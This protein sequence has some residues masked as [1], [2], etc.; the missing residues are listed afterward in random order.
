M[1]QEV[2]I[3][4]MSFNPFT[5]IDK[6]WM[7]ITAGNETKCNTMYFSSCYNVLFMI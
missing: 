2:D 4:K 5:K 3:K 7:L 6:E 1:F